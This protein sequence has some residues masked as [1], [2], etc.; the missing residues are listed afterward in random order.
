MAARPHSILIVDDDES[1]LDSLGTL[2]ERAGHTARK[3]H[4]GQEALALHRTKAADLIISDINMPFM[5]G[6]SFCRTLRE[7]Q[8]WVP[9]ILL[10]SRDSEI[11]EVLG[12]DLGADDYIAKPY[13]PRVLQSRVAT[14][15]RRKSAKEP[16]AEERLQ[17]HGLTL[18]LA[19]LRASFHGTVL[20]LT[21]SEVRLIEALMRR[22]GRVMTRERLLELAREDDAGVVAVRIVDT[23]IARIRRKLRA[24]DDSAD[25]VET[26]IGAGYRF[27]D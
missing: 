24:I 8:D 23:Y 9:L 18:D 1:L 25:L 11:D 26:V 27:K 22:P 4:H 3:A 21:V 14:L 5:D 16:E 2:M 15:L 12:L 19:Q 7:A 10:T 6:F 13:S 20:E 17:A